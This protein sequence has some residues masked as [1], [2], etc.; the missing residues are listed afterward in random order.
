MAAISILGEG[1]E[2]IVKQT[3]QTATQWGSLFPWST[4]SPQPTP[5]PPTVVQADTTSATIW[6]AIIAAIGVIGAAT[7]PQ[8]LKNRNGQTPE[9]REASKVVDGLERIS[10]M[11]ARLQALEEHGA[12]RVI[13]FRGHNG[14]GYPTPGMPFYVSA[15]QWHTTKGRDSDAI[16]NYRNLMVD[17]D[18][19]KMLLAAWTSS[20]Q[21]VNLITE[22]MPPCQLKRWYEAE[23]VSASAVFVMGIQNKAMFYLSAARYEGVF[24]EKDLTSIHLAVNG[25]WQDMIGGK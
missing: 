10:N 2:N 15:S 7:I 25:I 21:Y 4:P 8:W 20:G 11:S 17:S 19:V 6:A 5:T 23:G 12:E 3:Q 13:L 18:Y 16:A 24:T 14:G 22:T 1:V 9:E